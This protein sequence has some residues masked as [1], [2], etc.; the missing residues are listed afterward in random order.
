MHRNFRA[1]ITKLKK[2]ESKTNNER[3]SANDRNCETFIFQMFNL[4]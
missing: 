2:S 4:E 1:N 3:V